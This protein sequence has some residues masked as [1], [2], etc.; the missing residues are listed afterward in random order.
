MTTAAPVI[1]QNRDGLLGVL[2]DPESLRVGSEARIAVRLV[3]GRVVLVPVDLMVQQHDGSFF[4]D[5]EA[6]EVAQLETAA[7]APATEATPGK[8]AATRTAGDVVVPVVAETIEVEK[9]QV[10]GARVRVH[11]A[12]ATA[13]EVVRATLVHEHVDVER[14]PVNRVVDGPVA[15][16]QE[17]DTTVIPVVKEVLIVEKRL[18]LVEEVRITRR[19]VEQPFS[20]TVPVRTET[21]VVE[22]DDPAAGGADAVDSDRPD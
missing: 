15:N 10:E 5:L 6:A 22:R 8:A 11:K 18:M 4:L 20:Q 2:E 9:R 14:V 1:V 3:D 7:A 12:V 17:G 13:D 19:R 21:V 16:R